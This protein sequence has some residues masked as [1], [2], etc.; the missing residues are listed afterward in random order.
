MR[1]TT[2]A[3]SLAVELEVNRTFAALRGLSTS[4]SLDSGDLDA[5]RRQAADAQ[6]DEADLADGRA[7]LAFGPA[8]GAADGAA[9]GA[10]SECRAPAGTSSGVIADRIFRS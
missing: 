7:D 5:F 10:A 8:T 9:R 1:E 4:P 2:D 3:L 6:G